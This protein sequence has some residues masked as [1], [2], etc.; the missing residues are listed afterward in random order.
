MHHGHK[1]PRSFVYIKG[2]RKTALKNQCCLVSTE[3]H[4]GY[5]GSRKAIMCNISVFLS[6]PPLT[7]EQRVALPA[8]SL[9]ISVYL[10]YFPV[11]INIT[12]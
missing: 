12:A 4:A 6:H 7:P 8:R 9:F 1:R 11:D 3:L 5:Y 2:E 10:Y